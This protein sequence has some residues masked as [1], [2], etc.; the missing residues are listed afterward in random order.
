MEVAELIRR[1]NELAATGANMSETTTTTKEEWVNVRDV[2]VEFSGEKIIL[3]QRNGTPMPYP[4]AIEWLQRKAQEEERVVQISHTLDCS[5]LDGA[6]AFH[7]ALAQ[8]YGWADLVP[9]GG[10]WGAKPPVML[11]VPI[12]PDSTVQVP[13]GRVAV[14]GIDGHL[15]L[16]LTNTPRPCFMVIAE[17]K[18][19]HEKDVND[20]L[21]LTK[22][23]LS[24]YSIY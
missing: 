22:E 8:K 4:M 24:D 1:L 6:V 14:P 2:A 13:I 20:L 3:P 10:F 19:K 5:P 12:T 16:H 21:T 11:G 17:V 7:R 9:T 23:M 18:R 15:T